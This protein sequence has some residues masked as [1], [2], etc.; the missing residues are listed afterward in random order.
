M[1]TIQ[2]ADRIEVTFSKA[3]VHTGGPNDVTNA[4]NWTLN[5]KALENIASITVAD[6]NGDV[7]DGNEKVIITFKDA[8]CT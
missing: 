8:K 3:I 6:G 1:I 5:G 2:Q 7:K 4:A